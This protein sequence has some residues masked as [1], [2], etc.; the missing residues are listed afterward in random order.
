MSDL[1]SKVVEQIS[2]KKNA[3][4]YQNKDGQEM[5]NP[6]TEARLSKY[7][8]SIAADA[9]GMAQRSGRSMPSPTSNTSGPLYAGCMLPAGLCMRYT[10]GPLYAKYAAGKAVERGELL[11]VE[12]VERACLRQS[13]E[14]IAL[15][16]SG[17][18][19]G[20]ESA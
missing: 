18:G 4:C 20:V 12:L 2:A 1:P 19:D 10:R 17:V 5:F 14:S 7:V 6:A 16:A 9:G 8:S 11:A 13:R 15:A 3:L